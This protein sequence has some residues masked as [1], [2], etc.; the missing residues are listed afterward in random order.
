MFVKLCECGCSKEV[1]KETNRFI[2]HHNKPRLGKFK[3][4]P[5]DNTLVY[6][7]CCCGLLVKKS[8]Y[9]N[10]KYIYQHHHRGKKISKEHGKKIGD[11][12]RGSKSVNW[13]GG[14]DG[15]I[16]RFLKN[17]Y[18]ISKV[19]YDNLF[20]EQQGRCKIC[21]KHKS[22]L[23]ERLS[24]DH[25]HITG[26]VRGLLCRK[27]NVL[28]GHLENNMQ[29]LKMAFNYLDADKRILVTKKGDK[30]VVSY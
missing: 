14:L 30:S 9:G 10:T 20:N 6:C 2:N 24:V 7:E 17:H 29:I 25:N 13:K 21:S 4:P 23:K 15:K 19:E 11:A 26:K 3:Y 8:K 5:I 22:E 18:G 1:T 16:D 28:L 27:C 12:N